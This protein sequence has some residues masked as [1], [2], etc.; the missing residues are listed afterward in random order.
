[1]D[2][3]KVGKSKAKAVDS[4]RKVNFP[5]RLG[6]P[7]WAGW[8]AGDNSVFS[9]SFPLFPLGGGWA[10]HFGRPVIKGNFITQRGSHRVAIW[11]LHWGGGVGKGDGGRRRQIGSL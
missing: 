2:C 8:L 4:L 5:A 7:G 1:M 3:L 11:D 10:A 6:F 9:R